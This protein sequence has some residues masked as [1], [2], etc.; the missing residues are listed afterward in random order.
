[1]R[2]KFHYE[3]TVPT[4]QTTIENFLKKHQYSHA[5][6]VHLKK[7]SAGIRKNG[8]WARTSESLSL[9]DTLDILLEETDY[10]PNI[11]ESRMDLDIVYED[12]DLLVVNK[13]AG[14]P[15][16]PSLN[17]FE[18]TLANGI[19]YYYKKQGIPFTFRCVNRLDRDTS[20]LTIIAKHMLCSAILSSA[21]TRREIHREYLAIADGQVRPEGIIDAPI[22]RKSDSVIERMVDFEKG[23]HA[24]THYKCL[25]YKDGLSLLLLQLETGRTHQIRVHMNFIAH[26]LIG[27]FLYHP[28]DHRMNRQALHSYRLSFCH[29]I[30]GENLQ[31]TAP[32]PPDMCCFFQLPVC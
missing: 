11:V 16:H 25:A 3:I 13:P 29:P 12:E 22:A 31:F 30:T 14:I 17:H 5:V 19:L 9:G 2:R 21:V 32:M 10:S 26:P 1:M 18:H 6:I 28:S 15:I 27:D 23:E 4:D 24:V 7:T 8:V 20:G